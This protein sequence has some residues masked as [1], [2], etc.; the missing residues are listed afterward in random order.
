MFKMG[1]Q[2]RYDQDIKLHYRMYKAGKRW[3]VAGV[4]VMS[5][6]LV[7]AGKPQFVQA[8]VAEPQT[9]SEVAAKAK[10]D[11][12]SG[13]AANAATKTAAPVSQA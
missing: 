6:S 13:I 8:A 7:L 10:A 4:A 9:T 1:N 12:Q 11:Q 5:F 2:N 3:I